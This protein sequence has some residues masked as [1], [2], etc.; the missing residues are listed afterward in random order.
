[1]I[2]KAKRIVLIICTVLIAALL[3]ASLTSCL[4]IGM[5]ENNVRDRLDKAG[6]TVKYER[7]SPMT[8]E[9]QSGYK[10]GDIL[11]GTMIVRENVDGED[12]EK[13]ESVYVFFTGDTRSADWVQERC[14]KYVEENVDNISRWN[15]YR[16]EEVV[17]V[18]Y[19]KLVSIVRQY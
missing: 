14:K 10:I 12:V 13:E 6:V 1:L 11:H 15:V 19:Y 7:T 5:R 4:K 8:S 9:G 18:G 16:F 2:M 3:G 17:V